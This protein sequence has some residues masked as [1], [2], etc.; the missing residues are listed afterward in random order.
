VK[1]DHNDV[2]E[3]VVTRPSRAIS[4]Q[5]ITARIAR[6]LAG[7]AG[8]GEAKNL[9]IT[10][11]RDLGTIHVE[12]SATAE[13]TV[14]RMYFDARSGRFDVL[15]DLPGSTLARRAGMRFTGAVAETV[16]TAVLARTIDR[17]G[18]L[19]A[20]DVVVERRP[21]AEVAGEFIGSSDRA[22][23]LAARRA[24]RAGQVLRSS[25]LMR[26]EVVQRNESVTI[27]YEVPG[28]VLTA[29][30]KALEAGSEG[31][32][33][34]VLNIQSK[35]TVQATVTGPGRVTIN[36]PAPGQSMILGAPH[37]ALAQRS[38]H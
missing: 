19:R 5:E 18:V 36:T 7:Q 6:A 34:S 2:S 24:L 25:D 11:D 30:G 12:P 3:V 16:E 9:S 31:D 32:V 37:L 13:L 10:V 23:G 20:T 38:A 14:A 17:G 4:A 8:L 22:V 26:P 15:L 33:L 21:K 28:I 29:R 27:V 1:L 35:R